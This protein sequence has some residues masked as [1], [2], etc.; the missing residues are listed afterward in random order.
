VVYLLPIAPYVL[1][2]ATDFAGANLSNPLMHA[3]GGFS[4]W[5]GSD[6]MYRAQTHCLRN[7]TLTCPT[8]ER[9]LRWMLG[10]PSWQGR[11]HRHA[12]TLLGAEVPRVAYACDI[13]RGTPSEAH[14][15]Y[16]RIARSILI[17][18][19]GRRWS[20]R[21]ERE[22]G[23]LVTTPQWWPSFFMLNSTAEQLPRA[24]RELVAMK[25]V[26]AKTCHR[27]D[28]QVNEHCG[29]ENRRQLCVTAPHPTQHTHTH[30]R[31]RTHARTH[32]HTHTHTHQVLLLPSAPIFN[33]A[34]GAET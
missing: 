17:T 7:H 13:R 9:T 2:A 6:S 14:S 34:L 12:F 33:I 27:Y 25:S 18:T 20:W 31:A 24:K 19:E 10:R 22:Q 26:A 3:K 15:V 23:Y 21:S 1:C 5:R 30:T 16:S 32:T 4:R 8:Y 28:D 11:E 29:G